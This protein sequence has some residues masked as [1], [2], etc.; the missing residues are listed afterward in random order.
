MLYGICVTLLFSWAEQ[1]DRTSNRVLIAD[2]IRLEMR[3]C[4]SP[5]TTRLRHAWAEADRRMV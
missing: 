4:V 5:Q 3:V 2:S 1:A